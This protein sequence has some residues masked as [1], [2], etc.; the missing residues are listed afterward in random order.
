VAGMGIGFSD[1]THFSDNFS[2][3]NYFK[4]SYGLKDMNFQSFNDFM[5]FLD[6]FKSTLSKT[7]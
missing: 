4:P 3:I 6:L 1:S 2:Y 7:V 5:E